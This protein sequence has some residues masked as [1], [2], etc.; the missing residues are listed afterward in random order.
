MK[1]LG[2]L[3]LAAC[4]VFSP[5]AANAQT[6]PDQIYAELAKLPAAERQK[7]IESEAAK[8]ASERAKRQA[9]AER[10]R[11]KSLDEAAAKAKEAEARY[12]AELSKGKK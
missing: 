2:A 1:S 10:N 9:E 6:S 5:Q 12:Q 4:A 11:Q 8:T 7:R 3:V